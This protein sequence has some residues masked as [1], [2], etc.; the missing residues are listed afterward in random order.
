M[1]SHTNQNVTLLTPLLEYILHTCTARL[2]TS[3]FAVKSGKRW[4]SRS[5]NDSAES[6]RRTESSGEFIV[7]SY[8]RLSH[9]FHGPPVAVPA[10]PGVD[11]QQGWMKRWQRNDTNSSKQSRWD[12]CSEETKC[13]FVFELGCANAI[14]THWVFT[15]EGNLFDQSL[16]SSLSLS[17][18]RCRTSDRTSRWWRSVT[19]RR[20]S[21]NQ[22][23]CL[24][25]TLCIMATGRRISQQEALLK[26]VRRVMT[27]VKCFVPHS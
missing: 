24:W 16:C 23:C 12:D 13:V 11:T 27:C 5:R 1:R 19:W 15:D 14:Q 4:A 8:Q 10:R 2:Q 21:V 18:C 20:L 9:S 22:A 17:G 6:A 25:A 3:V 7:M 26:E